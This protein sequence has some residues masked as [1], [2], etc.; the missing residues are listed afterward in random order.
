MTPVTQEHP[1]HEP[2]RGLHGDC[3]SAALASLLDLPLA[4]VPHVLAYPKDQQREVFRE[5]LQ[6][7]GLIPVNVPGPAFR[8]AFI[9]TGINCYHLILGSNDGCP[10]ACVGLNGAIV[11]DPLPPLPGVKWGLDGSL[12][13]WECVVFVKAFTEAAPPEVGDRSTEATHQEGR[14]P[15]NNE[16]K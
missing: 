14:A 3:Y 2:S 5:F 8:S 7:H 10:H 16:R 12:D 1:Y 4:E 6:V 11:H 13:D 9:E 15:C